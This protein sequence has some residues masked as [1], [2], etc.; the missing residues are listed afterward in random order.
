V[1]ERFWAKV[2]KSGGPDVCWPWL[3]A[4]MTRTGYG[5]M[6]VDGRPVLTHRLA[7]ELSTGVIPEGLWVL[8]SCDNRPCCNPAHLFLGTHTDNMRDCAAKGRNGGK[9]HPERMARGDKNGARVHIER[10]TRGEAQHLARLTEADVRAIRTMYS[11]SPRPS[12]R[13]IANVFGVNPATIGSVIKRRTW[14]H[15]V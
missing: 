15:V 5:Q 2:D 4:K 13:T 9:T 14:V 7:Y 12:Y 11:M 6:E 1:A 8:H 3:G 10:M